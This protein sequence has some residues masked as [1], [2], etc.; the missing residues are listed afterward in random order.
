MTAYIVRRLLSGLLTLFLFMTLLFFVVNAAIPG[1]Y[2]T[3]LGPLT[4]DAAEAARESLGIDR[5]LYEQYF[6]WLGSFVT[7]DLGTSFSGASVWETIQIAIAPTLV[8]LSVGLGLAFV[9]GGWLGRLSGFKGS[10]FEAG[11]LTFI[12]ILCLTLFPPALAVAMERSVR[13][14][15]GWR[16]LGEFGTIDFEGFVELSPSDVLWR[17]FLVFVATAL[18]LWL[19]ETLIFRFTRK[20]TPRWVFLIAMVAL[21][22]L[23]WSQL[24]VADQVIDLAGAMSLLLVAVVLLTFGEVLL[25]T[26]AS[27]D[28]VMMEDYV[29]VAR[30]KGLPEQ[31]VR[32]RHAARTA[33]LPVL[34]RFTV[35]IPYFLT[36][37]VILEVVFGG[38]QTGAGLQIV[39]T[40]QRVSAPVGLG[41]L[42]FGALSN[43]DYPLLIGALV[44]VGILT[45]LIRIVL[46]V[47][48]VAL[49]PRIRLGEVGE[50]E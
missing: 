43:Q 11:S 34:S 19:L 35:A 14:F 47:V 21:P 45:L 10:S 42:L 7:F 3:S 36:G 41:S 18:L 16:G 23:I 50:S 2:V 5:P 40:L 25:V 13:S 44:V 17:V 28:D 8:V 48:H 27:M 20:R 49:D 33:L 29:M 15:T 30:A 46:D 24:G 31:Q 39:G 1:D 9:L 12:A 22:L 38:A 6:D 26:R 32:D 37:L 4:A